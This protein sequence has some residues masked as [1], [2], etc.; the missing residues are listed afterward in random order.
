MLLARGSS[1]V[2][3][4]LTPDVTVTV[5]D[6]VMLRCSAV[7]DPRPEFTWTKRFQGFPENVRK[8]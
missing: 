2:V 3:T 4:V 1:P 7:G 6:D 5:G 8:A